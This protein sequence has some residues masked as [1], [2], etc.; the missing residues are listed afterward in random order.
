MRVRTAASQLKVRQWD[1]RIWCVLEL[2]WLLVRE[3]VVCG[4]RFPQGAGARRDLLQLDGVVA[5][6]WCASFLVRG[7]G[8]V[9]DS[10]VQQLEWMT[11]V[12]SYVGTWKMRCGEDGSCEWRMLRGDGVA[13]T[14]A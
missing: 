14:G 7:G 12:A 10:H 8:S 3:M 6:L 4:C 2:Q 9:K 1:S 5:D 11:V 13:R